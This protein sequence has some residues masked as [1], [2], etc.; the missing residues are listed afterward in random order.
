[1]HLAAAVQTPCVAIFAAR[2]IP[3]I[4]F[5]YGLQHRVLYHHVDCAGCELETCIVQ[6]K[7]CLTSIT[8]DEVL[9]EVRAILGCIPGHPHVA[10]ARN[11]MIDPGVSPTTHASRPPRHPES[12]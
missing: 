9:Q 2:N 7:K 12:A 6:Q 11:A 8:V 4:W 3:R 5:P 10:L 1:M